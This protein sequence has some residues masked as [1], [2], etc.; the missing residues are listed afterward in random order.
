MSQGAERQLLLQFLDEHVFEPV[1]QHP[2][3]RADRREAFEDAQ[4]RIERTW[5][6]CH[7]CRSA[8]ELRSLCIESLQSPVALRADRELDRLGLPTLSL[9]AARFFALCDE[10]GVGGGRYAAGAPA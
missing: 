8:E 7:A 2:P 9:L 6:R 1:L 5:A 4:A 3:D 10:L